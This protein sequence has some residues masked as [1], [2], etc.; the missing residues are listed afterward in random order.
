MAEHIRQAARKQKAKERNF[1]VASNQGDMSKPR[2]IADVLRAAA[3]AIRYSSSSTRLGEWG[4]LAARQL[5]AIAD[6][7][8]RVGCHTD[9]T[10]TQSHADD[11]AAEGR[12]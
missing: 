2:G 8:I 4:A 5:N 7:C 6:D 3:A 9:R 12:G 1:D 10:A 11:V